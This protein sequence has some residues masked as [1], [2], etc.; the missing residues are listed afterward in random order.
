MQF[1]WKNIKKDYFYVNLTKQDFQNQKWP[2][3][4]LFKLSN[5]L[6]FDIAV[7]QFSPE[8]NKPKCTHSALDFAYRHDWIKYL[9]DHH[10]L[11]Y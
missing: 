11:K 1:F 7:K 4:W 8:V 10:K 6:N 2:G 9:E 3:D 5:A